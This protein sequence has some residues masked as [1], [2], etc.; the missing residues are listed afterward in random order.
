MQ[1]KFAL[2]IDSGSQGVRGCLIDTEGNVAATATKRYNDY[3]SSSF[4]LVEAPPEMRAVGRPGR[5]RTLNRHKVVKKVLKI[6]M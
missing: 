1:K 3:Y 2:A 4:G 6:L 5:K